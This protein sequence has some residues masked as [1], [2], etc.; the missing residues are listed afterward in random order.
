MAFADLL[1]RF[2]EVAHTILVP[3][4]AVIDK[5]IGDEVMA[6]FIP[7]FEPNYRRVAIE[8]AI[9]IQQALQVANDGKP[10]LPVGIGIHAGTAFVGKLGTEDIHDWLTPVP[11]PAAVG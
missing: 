11:K 7:S 6:F 3:R 1:N 8:S 2:Y 5:M 4:R 10:L 9:E